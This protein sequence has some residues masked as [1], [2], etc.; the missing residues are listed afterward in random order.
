MTTNNDQPVMY[1]NEVP[2]TS[3]LATSFQFFLPATQVDFPDDAAKQALLADQWD[4]NLTGFTEQGMVGNPWNAS[5][6]SP[7]INYF[8]PKT[9]PIPA[10]TPTVPITWFVF[11]NRI[12]FYCANLG[13]QDIY[14]LADTGY[15]QDGKTSFP[16]ITNPCT[17]D[18][19]LF[20]PY[21]PRGWQDE[22]C[23][24][25]ITKDSNGNITRIDFTCESP[26]YWNTLWM[27]DPE[28]VLAI[29][30]STLNK[31]QIQLSDLYLTDAN[32]N[33]V[34][35]PSTGRPLYNPLNIWNSGTV[36]TVTQGGA[37]HLTS[38]PNTLQTD[39]GLA[40]AATIQRKSGN[41]N[42]DTLICCAQFGQ[43]KRNSDPHIGQSVNKDVASGLAI[44]LC[45]PPGL[46]M[47]LP[48]F[49]Q[50]KFPAGTTYSDYYKIVRG[51]E[52]LN[53]ENGDPLPGNFI[54][55]AVFEAPAGHTIQEVSINKNGTYVP[56]TWAGQ[57]S[58]T[59]NNQIVA[60]G[61]K[62]T[63]PTP[64]PCV[65]N[66]SVNFAGPL[67]LFHASVFNA[68][69]AEAISNPVG[70]AM[71]LVSN[72]TMIAPIVKAGTTS[73]DMVLTCTTVTTSPLPTVS[74][75]NPGIKVEV[76]G[77]ENT[78]YA[79]PGNSYPSPCV[80]LYLTVSVAANAAVGLANLYLTNS[81][82]SAS[83][84]MPALINIIA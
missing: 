37:M 34:I 5:Y 20:G 73:V 1:T 10:G 41:A 36:S 68:M 80:A 58:E 25:S 70:M 29:Y 46:Y 48:D 81:G 22:Y 13:Q 45:N 44:S 71:S 69:N 74:F 77:F 63:A 24:W 57:I 67:Q 35:D 56:I 62:A 23:E 64:M 9:T 2:V 16:E 49:S 8:N 65:G 21:G 15:M 31:P 51:T 33:P 72:S 66:L 83:A 43:P 38:T 14:S 3:E 79:V 55:H 82:Q 17:Q 26:E 60:Y 27:I 50:Y 39:I 61:L 30:Q 12:N 4:T 84:P 7:I 53:D 52:T 18:K 28:Q 75:D 32:N 40:N 59:I 76:T 42:P 6:A 47:Q 54:L 11:P 19:V 78:Q